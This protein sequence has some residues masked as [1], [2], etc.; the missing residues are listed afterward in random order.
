M[1]ASPPSKD[2]ETEANVNKA[3]LTNAVH[4]SENFALDLGTDEEFLAGDLFENHDMRLIRNDEV[5][6]VFYC[7]TCVVAKQ[8]REAER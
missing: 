6:Y 2:W 1:S 5:G 4:K 8:E 3:I 7:H